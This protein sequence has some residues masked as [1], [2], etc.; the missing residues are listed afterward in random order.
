M[1]NA[2][3][4]LKGE[5][6]AFDG[7]GQLSLPGGT[8][9]AADPAAGYV[10]LPNGIISPLV[11]VSFEAWVTWAGPASAWQRIFDFGTSA[12]GE[13]VVDGNGAYFF[14]SPAGDANLRFA[15]RDPRTGGEPTQLTA[16]APLPR[17]PRSMSPRSITT[18]ATLAV[19]YSNAVQVAPDRRPSR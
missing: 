6:A 15:V 19:L 3:G 8:T 4:V 1:G 11:N 17:A 10:D 12:G 18:P 9:S 13:D 2:D 14:L 5:G 7:N 16:S